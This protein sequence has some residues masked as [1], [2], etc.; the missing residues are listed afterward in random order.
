[1][2]SPASRSKWY[3]INFVAGIPLCTVLFVATGYH[4]TVSSNAQFNSFLVLKCKSFVKDLNYLNSHE[5]KLFR[6]HSC[7]LK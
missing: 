2:E 3:V 5:D 4:L 1:M 6:I 7:V